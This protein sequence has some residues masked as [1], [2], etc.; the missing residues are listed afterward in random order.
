Q[1][2][3]HLHIG[4]AGTKVPDEAAGLASTLSSGND[5]PAAFAGALV[6]G[7]GMI[8][9]AGT[10]SAVYGEAADGRSVLIGGWGPLAGDEGSGFAIGR[11][12]LRA[13]TIV[14]DGRGT[15]SPLTDALASHLNV[16]TRESMQARMYHPPMPREDIAALTSI[17]AGAAAEG[18]EVA[19]SILTAAACDLAA[20]VADGARLLDL[21][22]ATARVST[23]GGVWSAGPL[24]LQPFTE[25]LSQLVP[26]AS[27]LPARYPPVVGALLI[28]YRRAGVPVSPA[29]LDQ[30]SHGLNRWGLQ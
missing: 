23:L 2:L 28:A 5:G 19:R 25:H 27:V 1:P 6:E 24:V 18:D 15:A 8:V 17:V 3:T 14:L 20:T 22:G 21:H 4:A 11:D 12:A 10:G 30:L 16:S 29:M 7:P 26:G 9:I 13:L